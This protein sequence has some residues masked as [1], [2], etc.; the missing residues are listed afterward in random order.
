VTLCMLMSGHL[1]MRS[2]LA[3][4]FFNSI[5]FQSIFSHGVAEPG[6]LTGNASGILNMA[7]VGGRDR[8]TD[9]GSECR[10]Y[11][12]SSCFLCARDWRLANLVVRAQRIEAKQRTVRHS[13]EAELRS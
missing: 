6:P 10:P 8:P 9:P 3:V 13:L 1:A 5:M 4:G 11:R 12:N 7:I 2:M